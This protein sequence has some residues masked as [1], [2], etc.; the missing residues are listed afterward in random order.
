MEMKLLLFNTIYEQFLKSLLL[1]VSVFR[2]GFV[3]TY[4][5]FISFSKKLSFKVH[6]NLHIGEKNL[7]SF[8]NPTISNLHSSQVFPLAYAWAYVAVAPSLT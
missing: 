1:G 7:N 3:Q 2:H 4:M 8:S 5:L 6:S